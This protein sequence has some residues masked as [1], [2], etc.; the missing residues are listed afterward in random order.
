MKAFIRDF[1]LELRKAFIAKGSKPH[2]MW[3][4]DALKMKYLWESANDN[5]PLEDAD[6]A[7]VLGLHRESIRKQLK[8]ILEECTRMLSEK[9]YSYYGIC[10]SPEMQAELASFKS[11]LKSVEVLSVILARINAG[12]DTR[13]PLFFLEGLGYKCSKAFCINTA[14]FGEK[15]ITVLNKLTSS[16]N[17]GRLAKYFKEESIPL[18][19]MSDVKVFM[20]S[21]LRYDDYQCR[22]IEA[23]LRANTIE[24]EWDMDELGSEIVALKWEHLDA[25][26]NRQARIVYDFNKYNG[27]EK[28]ISQDEICRKYHAL[29]VEKGVDVNNDNQNIQRHKHIEFLGK[30]QFRFLANPNTP[31][32][33][34]A[35]QLERFVV[36]KGGTATLDEVKQFVL[37][38]NPSYSENTILQD[39]VIKANCRSMRTDGVR[40]IVHKTH[41]NY[42]RRA[43]KQLRADTAIRTTVEILAGEGRAFNIKNELI[44][45]F[46]KKIGLDKVNDYT[47]ISMLKRAEGELFGFQ[48]SAIEL[49]VSK[50]DAEIYPYEI[51]APKAPGRKGDGSNLIIRNLAVEQLLYAPGHKMAKKALFDSVQNRYPDGKAK[52]GIYKVFQSDPIFID[53]DAKGKGGSYTLDI[54]L[55]NKEHGISSSVIQNASFDWS[56]LKKCIVSQM[57]NPKLDELA[58]E[59][60]IRIMKSIPNIPF[61]NNNEFWRMLNLLDRYYAQKTNDYETMLLAWMLFLGVENYL[62]AYKPYPNTTTTGLGDYIATLQRNGEFPD[63]YAT[64]P[65]GSVSFE[66]SRMTGF[67]IG[68]RNAIGHTLNQGYNKKSFLDQSIKTAVKYYLLI[69][70]FA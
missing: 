26:K 62:R 20:K 22:I 16:G 44:P 48:D 63:R 35:S 13:T 57:K 68:V 27:W 59:K 54:A 38:I 7:Q 3:K 37:N 58:C 52:T 29:A 12:G 55:Y 14:E 69:A 24:Y 61:D 10:A 39:M 34:I 42:K 41:S 60:M 49:L 18:R 32:V 19:F 45:L 46:T 5:A 8:S 50:E 9:N 36:S 70:A 40:Y 4:I 47:L 51:Y 65:I 66:I 17:N 28:I 33:D 25:V 15:G 1:I 43:Q 6:I 53:S 64:Y 31:K 67:I 11:E 30:R 2:D 56:T 23:Y 21:I